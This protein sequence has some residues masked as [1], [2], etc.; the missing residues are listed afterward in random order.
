MRTAPTGQVSCPTPELKI[1]ARLSPEA[2]NGPVG[3]HKGGEKL[4]NVTAGQFRKPAKEQRKSLCKW[5][6]ILYLTSLSH[7]CARERPQKQ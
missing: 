7:G 2:G 6:L 5:T 4:W 3:G 1:I